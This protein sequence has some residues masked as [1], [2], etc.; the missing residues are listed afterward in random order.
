MQPQ[1]KE[2][3]FR[4]LDESSDGRNIYLNAVELRR[5]GEISDGQSLLII[6][7]A[8]GLLEAE[9]AK[10]DNSDP[11]RRTLLE[12]LRS[13]YGK[14][15]VETFLP[16]QHRRVQLHHN[17]AHYINRAVEVAQELGEYQN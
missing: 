16:P 3:Q 1:R 17:W 11:H 2:V 7:R 4:Q 13:C 8:V 5:S 14:L 10:T 12:T 9:I 6:D 15:S